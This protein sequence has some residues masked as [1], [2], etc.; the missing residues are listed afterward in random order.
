M[1]KTRLLTC[2]AAL[3]LCLSLQSCFTAG[4]WSSGLRDRAK[5]GLTPLSL[6]LDAVTLPAQ[7]AVI[8]GGHGFHHNHHHH[9]RR[10]RRCR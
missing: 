10:G 6:A 5:A 7:L 9:G 4:L 1:K 8:G 3:I 2:A